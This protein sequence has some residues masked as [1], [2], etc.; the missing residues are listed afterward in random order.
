M[1]KRWHYSGDI[2]LEYGGYFWK[3]DGADDY[4]LAVRV[5]P[6]ADAGGPSNMF[7]IEPGS[8]YLPAD[9]EKRKRALDCCGWISTDKPTRAMLVDA[10]LAYNGIDKDCYGQ[11]TV[12][13]G[14]PE[15]G[16][17]EWNDKIVP[18]VQLRGNASLKNYV[19]KE[20]LR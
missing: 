8:I 14:K 7:W 5:T 6:C 10:F 2:N 9:A 17:S 19:R 20:F 4:V 16:R 11:T 1:A 3:E 18:D 12:S 13:I 15:S